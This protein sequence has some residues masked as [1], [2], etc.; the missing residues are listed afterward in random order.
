MASTGNQVHILRNPR[1]SWL[2]IVAFVVCSFVASINIILRCSLQYLSD[3]LCFWCGQVFVPFLHF[4]S[5]QV[6]FLYICLFLFIFVS[7]FI[8]LSQFFCICLA[9][10]NFELTMRHECFQ[11]KLCVQLLTYLFKLSF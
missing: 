7:T 10:A 9:G 11:D 8:Y 1:I 4:F 5:L 3:L 6:P 2:F